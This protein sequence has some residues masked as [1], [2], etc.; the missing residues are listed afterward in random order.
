MVRL[1]CFMTLVKIFVRAHEKTRFRSRKFENELNEDYE[2]TVISGQIAFYFQVII[3][4]AGFTNPIFV[5]LVSETFNRLLDF[6]GAS[7]FSTF[8]FCC[9]KVS[10]T[11]GNPIRCITYFVSSFPLCTSGMLSLNITEVIYAIFFSG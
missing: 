7:S 11:F 1:E 9:T 2:N 4:I 6:G 10:D 5:K 3:S 8:A